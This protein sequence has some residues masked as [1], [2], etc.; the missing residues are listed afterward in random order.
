MGETVVSVRD[1][2][3]EHQQLWE[4]A[5]AAGGEPPAALDHV[6]SVGQRTLLFDIEFA[7]LFGETLGL[8]ENN[9]KTG[10]VGLEQAAAAL[11]EHGELGEPYV[12]VDV[13]AVREEVLHNAHRLLARLSSTAR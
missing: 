5:T 2:T 7:D 9:D 3:D 4:V 1:A 13:A 8:R 6:D 10:R 11:G 12:P